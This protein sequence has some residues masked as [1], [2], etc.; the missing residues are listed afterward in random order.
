MLGARVEAFDDDGRAVIGRQ[1]ELVIT[2]PMPSMPVAF[3]RDED[4]S[5]MRS[6][7]FERFPGV[8]APRRLADD[9]RPRLVRGHGPLRCH[10]EPR[11]RALGHAEF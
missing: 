7:Y 6:A 3:W 8:L 1:G 4:G 11:G 2:A 9:H 10:A 5:R